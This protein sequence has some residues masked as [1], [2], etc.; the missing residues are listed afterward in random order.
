M[1]DSLTNFATAAGV[2]VGLGV[3]LFVVRA[4][5]PKEAKTFG[6]EDREKKVKYDS[7][8]KPVSD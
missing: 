2:M 7:S 3:L 8:G 5:R 4:R 1:A 6:G